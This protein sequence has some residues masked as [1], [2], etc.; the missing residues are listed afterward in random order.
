MEHR[1]HLH[2]VMGEFETAK[3]LLQAV[4]KVRDAGYRNMDAYAPFPVEGLSEAMGLRRSWVPL[5]TLL[6]GL[7]GGL[8]GFGFQYWVNVLA[9]PL[10]IAGRPLNSWPAFIPVTFELTILGASIFAVVGMLAMNKLPHPYHPVFNVARFGRASTDRFF[11]CIEATDPKFSVTDS[12]RFL[13]SLE[14]V[15]VTEVIEEE[16]PLEHGH[17]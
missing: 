8:T 13:Q 17:A 5:V 1:S 10:N 11:I 2:G 15:H 7:T 16:G 14:A 12:A 3:H 9:Y 4:A 6:G